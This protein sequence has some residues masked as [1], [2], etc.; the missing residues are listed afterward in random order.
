MATLTTEERNKIRNAAERK[1]NANDIPISWVKGAINDAAQ[2][3]EAALSG[4]IPIQRSECEPITGTSFEVIVSARID[5]A[6]VPYSVIFTN[7][8][9][10]WIFAYVCG[11]KS[12]RD[13]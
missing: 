12:G 4:D 13:G 9:K 5:V 10:R 2:V 1:A 7:Q 6:T 3:I 11:A 8:E